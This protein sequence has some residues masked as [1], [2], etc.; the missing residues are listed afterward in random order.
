MPSVAPSDSC[1]IGQPDT[2]REPGPSSHIKSTL[3]A[4]FSGIHSV[5]I[6][7]DESLDQVLG[8]KTVKDIVNELNVNND[9]LGNNAVTSIKR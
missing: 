4:N 9:T 5:L 6:K 2:V 3:N 8:S 7:V 1:S